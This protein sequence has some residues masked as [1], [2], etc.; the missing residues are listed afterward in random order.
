MKI[1]KACEEWK[2]DSFV[3][4]SLD[5]RKIFKLKIGGTTLYDCNAH[6]AVPDR[7]DNKLLFVSVPSPGLGLPTGV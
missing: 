7:P 1:T 6:V 2:K 4:M 3:G 5:S